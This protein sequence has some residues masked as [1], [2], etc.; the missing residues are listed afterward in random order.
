MK[1]YICADIEGVAGVASFQHLDPSGFEYEAARRWMTAE[2]NA[3]IAG[4]RA[5]GVDQFLI[6]DSH[7]NG[8]NIL[9]DDLPRDVRI[10][11]SWPRPL[12]MM[13]GL[14][15]GGFSGA[16]LIGHHS[17]HTDLE[18]A[19]AHTISGAFHEIRLNDAPASETRL[20]AAIAGAFGVPVL[21]ATGDEAYIAG[22]RALLGDVETVA[23][24]KS[25]SD[26]CVDTITP[27]A[28]CA[29]IEAAASRAAAAHATRAV[30]RLD[31]PV[32][33]EIVFK[34]RLPAQVISMWPGVARTAATSVAFE[35]QDILEAAR[36]IVVCANYDPSAR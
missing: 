35:A 15:E 7:G 32:R 29:L 12:E 3:A 5:A 11:R 4:A 6:S 31:G 10:V 22:A 23:T 13:Q 33:V 30:Y 9:L 18:G 24:K 26:Y 20:N 8:Q 14:E 16:F 2:V 36:M 34:Q 19:I 17:G 27:A 1:I 28:S 25:F 21:L